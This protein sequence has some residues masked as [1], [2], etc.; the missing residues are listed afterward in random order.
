MFIICIDFYI[1]ILFFVY[2]VFKNSNTFLVLANLVH[3]V[4][5]NKSGQ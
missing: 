4:K 1:F 5:L 3:K 2:I